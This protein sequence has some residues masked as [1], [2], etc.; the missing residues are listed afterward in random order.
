LPGV[1]STNAP[2]GSA[3]QINAGTA[4]SKGFEFDGDISPMRGLTFSFAGAHLLQKFDRLE[5][6]AIL[7]PFF[8]SP[9]GFTGAPEWS[10]QYAADYSFDLGDF[11]QMSLHGDY[12]HIDHYLQGP[13][14]L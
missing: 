9:G 4:T 10:Y 14:R 5:A 7:A 12:Y 3:L 11:G 8:H 13:V 2:S 6:P 1:D